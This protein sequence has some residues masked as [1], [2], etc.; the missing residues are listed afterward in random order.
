M[1]EKIKD[2]IWYEAQ[3]AKEVMLNIRRAHLAAKH[4][5]AEKCIGILKTLH[6][7]TADE[8]VLK[9]IEEI[10]KEQNNGN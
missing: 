6:E 5:K 7:N 2:R 4:D 9:L 10:K 1:N 8:R 3:Y